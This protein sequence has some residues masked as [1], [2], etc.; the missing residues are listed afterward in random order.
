MLDNNQAS[1]YQQPASDHPCPSINP[2]D[3]DQEP[4]NRLHLG[5]LKGG[6]FGRGDNLNKVNHLIIL[7]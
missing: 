7:G 2:D 1:V 6:Y 4:E 5:L 3:N